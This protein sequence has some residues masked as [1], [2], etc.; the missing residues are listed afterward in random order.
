M[1]SV[2]IWYLPPGILQTYSKRTVIETLNYVAVIK[3][4]I[5]IGLTIIGTGHGSG[6]RFELINHNLSTHISLVYMSNI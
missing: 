6:K 2:D 5:A 3:L 1:N 4:L